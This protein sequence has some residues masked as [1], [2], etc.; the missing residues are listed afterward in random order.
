MQMTHLC[1]KAML[2]KEYVLRPFSKSYQ[3]ARQKNTHIK[4]HMT[5]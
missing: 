4:K 3:P 5:T 1:Y 2:I